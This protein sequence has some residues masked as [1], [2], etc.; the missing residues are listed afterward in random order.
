MG[1]TVREVHHSSPNHIRQGEIANETSIVN[2]TRDSRMVV[3]RG[4]G[5]TWESWSGKVFLRK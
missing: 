3:A 4:G 5:V 1:F 2:M